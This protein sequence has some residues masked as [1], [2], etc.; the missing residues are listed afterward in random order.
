ME[1]LY[2]VD[3]IT[4]ASRLS[5]CFRLDELLR[6]EHNAMGA[7]LR[8][9]LITDI[10]W[11]TYLKNTFEQKSKAIHAGINVNRAIAEKSTFWVSASITKDI[12]KEVVAL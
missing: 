9:G 8:Q 7:K 3:C 11:K 5:F 12:V 4:E 2:P 6:I 1:I 10:E